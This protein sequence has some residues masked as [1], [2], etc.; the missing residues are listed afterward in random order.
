MARARGDSIPTPTL[1]TID[2]PRACLSTRLSQ[3]PTRE[4]HDQSHLVGNGD[5]LHRRDQ[6]TAWVI[7]AH[8]GFGLRDGA[9]G[10]RPNRLVMNHERRGVTVVGTID[11]LL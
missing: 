3:N 1:S 8:Q 9:R 10:D 2:L 6:P 4:R 11:A 5:E 7:P